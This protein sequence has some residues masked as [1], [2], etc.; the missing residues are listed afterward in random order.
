[1]FALRVRGDATTIPRPQPGRKEVRLSQQL[2]MPPVHYPE[3]DGKPMAE[4]TLQA[5]WIETLHGNLAAL[6][7][8]DPNVFVAIDNLWYPVENHPEICQAPDV[9]VV[10]GRPKKH[11][12]CYKQW[13]EDNV[14]IQ[15]VFE[16]RS[17]S[18][19]G[20]E[21]LDKEEFYDEYGV[22]EYYL[23]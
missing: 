15:V 2:L 10:F 23:Y 14:A 13:E 8:D 11:R 18:N 20:D 19:T 22:E 7:R 21:L 9:Y 1:R 6:Y 16:I 17:P 12:G 4:N 3:R 5:Q